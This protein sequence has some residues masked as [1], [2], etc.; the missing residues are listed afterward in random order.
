MSIEKAMKGLGVRWLRTV[1]SYSIATMVKVLRDAMTTAQG[2]LKVIIADGECQLARQRRIRPRIA[3][4]LQ[5]GVRVV[6]TRFG[7]DDDV[8]TGDHSCIRLSG[9]PSLTIKPSPDP[10]RTDPVAQV[11]NDCV[12]C[13]VCGE[14]AHAAVLCPSFYEAR[15][16]QNPAW[17]DRALEKVRRFVIGRLAS[18]MGKVAAP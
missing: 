13:G 16:V 8:C 17:H 7:V 18:G 2:G 9:C 15:I 3:K 1:R 12:G 14:V 4:Q 5:D 10:L 11:N 6:R